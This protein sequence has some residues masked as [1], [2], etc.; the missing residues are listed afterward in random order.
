MAYLYLDELIVGEA[1]SDYYILKLFYYITGRKPNKV[2]MILGLILEITISVAL[3]VTNNRDS[4]LLMLFITIFLFRGSIKLSDFLHFVLSCIIM[5]GVSVIMGSVVRSSFLKTV[6][7][8]YI[9]YCLVT[10][11][12]LSLNHHD[13]IHYAH[14]VFESGKTMDARLFCD[15]GCFLTDYIILDINSISGV[16]SDDEI[17]IIKS[18]SGLS[19]P[20]NDGYYPVLVN[21]LSG[22]SVLCGVNVKEVYID[23]EKVDIKVCFSENA[24]NLKLGCGGIMGC[25][26]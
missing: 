21:T 23:D 6:S 7:A 11:Y 8:P 18:V 24:L 14:I 1:I 20:I 15:T 22:Y 10:T 25:R 19:P 3:F 5:I 2:P 13:S 16:F 17:E 26:A 4:L 12:M 9:S